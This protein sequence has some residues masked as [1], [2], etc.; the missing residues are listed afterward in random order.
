M[1][2]YSLH[3][4]RQVRDELGAC[5][6]GARLLLLVLTRKWQT[7]EAFNSAGGIGVCLRYPTISAYRRSGGHATVARSLSELRR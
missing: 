5:E 1:A 6:Q 3:G 7:V 2:G 4:I